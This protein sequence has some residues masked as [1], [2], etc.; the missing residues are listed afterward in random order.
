MTC[1]L[2]CCFS[3]VSLHFSAGRTLLLS[4]AGAFSPVTQSALVSTER[5]PVPHYSARLLRGCSCSIG[6]VSG[7]GLFCLAPLSLANLQG[8]IPGL[9]AARGGGGGLD[10]S[11]SCFLLFTR[12]F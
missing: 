1:K 12:Q 2:F 9:S 4:P 5:I 8:S 7:S 10:S 11:P 3:F 6:V